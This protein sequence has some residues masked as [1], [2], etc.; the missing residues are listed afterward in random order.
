MK[1]PSARNPRSVGG[2]RIFQELTARW[3]GERRGRSHI[4]QVLG[5]PSAEAPPTLRNI[6]LTLNMGGFGKI[7]QI[8]GYV[9]KIA[10]NLPAHVGESLRGVLGDCK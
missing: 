3:L 6:T 9:V 2:T 1:F 5:C 10:H 7:T 4:E 8:M